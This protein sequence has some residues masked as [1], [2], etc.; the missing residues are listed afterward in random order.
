MEH[1]KPAGISCY[2]THSYLKSLVLLFQMRHIDSAASSARNSSFRST[3]K[4]SKLFR[5]SALRNGSKSLPQMLLMLVDKP[6][7]DKTPN[8]S[9]RDKYI[10]K[11][12]YGK[13]HTLD[14]RKG[15]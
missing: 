13:M 5:R 2:I 1:C 15:L 9:T 11:R 14:R 7:T 6:I 10:L 8:D 3:R 12:G 4:V